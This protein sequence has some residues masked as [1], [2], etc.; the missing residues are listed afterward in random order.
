MY[1]PA[2]FVE[3]DGSPVCVVGMGHINN[4]MDQLP[5]GVWPHCTIWLVDES[6]EAVKVVSQHGTK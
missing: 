2:Y 5:K 3:V 4:W 6:G 1:D